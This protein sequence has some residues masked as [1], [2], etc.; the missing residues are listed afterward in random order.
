MKPWRKDLLPDETG[1]DFAAP[2]KPSFATG[3]SLDGDLGGPSLLAPEV[4]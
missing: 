3:S 1:V 4:E 2:V